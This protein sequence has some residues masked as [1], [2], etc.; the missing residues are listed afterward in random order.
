[1]LP[2]IFASSSLV[3]VHDQENTFMGLKRPQIKHLS[4]IFGDRLITAK[5]ELFLSSSDVGAL[6]KMV[7]LMMNYNPDAIVQPTSAEE[8]KALYKFITYMSTWTNASRLFFAS[9]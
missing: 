9:I 5:H 2:T 3:E 1:M 7:G 8:I 4:E 6:P